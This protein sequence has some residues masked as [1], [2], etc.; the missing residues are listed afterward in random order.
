M[1]DDRGE[2]RFTDVPDGV[3]SIAADLQGFA[4]VTASINPETDRIAPVHL[5]LEIAALFSGLTVTGDAPP[6]PRRP[7]S[8]SGERHATR[9]SRL[10]ATSRCAC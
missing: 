4:P 5:R 6:K 8:T 1:S 7:S 10:S 2:F 9:R 3:C